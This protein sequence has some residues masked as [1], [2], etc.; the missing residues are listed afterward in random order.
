MFSA[1][2]PNRRATVLVAGIQMD[3][4]WEDVKENFRRA[5]DLVARASGGGARLVALPEMFATGF[6]MRA[7]ELSERAEETREFLSGLAKKEGCHLLGGFVDSAPDKPANVCSLFDPAGAEVLCYRKIHPFTL[8]GESDHYTAGETLETVTV[9]GIGVTPL[10]CYD[11]RFP[12]LFRAAADRTA[13]YVV[14]ANWPEPR[15]DAWSVLLRA[16]AIENQAFVLGV[17]RVG[18]GGGHTYLG[19]S[20]LLNPLGRVVASGGAG[21]EAVAGSVEREE[22]GRIRESLGFLRDRR[23][24]LYR[25][26]EEY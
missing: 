20:A 11:L 16:R 21:I 7:Q 2:F 12:E 15:R 13:L 5:E 10:I 9:E 17:N 4:A 8:G 22:V 18:E 1:P 19:D 6:S 3:I 26:L 23:P 24:A 14:V 25:R